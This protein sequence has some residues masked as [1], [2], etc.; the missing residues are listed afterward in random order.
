MKR[1]HIILILTIVAL[2]SIAGSAGAETGQRNF[3]AHLAG[4]GEVPAVDT[5][6]QGQAIFQLNEDGT[7]LH[8]KLIAANIDNLFM[9]HIHMGPAD[10]T[11]PI[12]VWL[13]LHPQ[14]ANPMDG[15][16]EGRFDGVLAEG[17]ITADDLT[18]PLGGGSLGDLLEAMRAGNTY[19]NVHTLQNPSGEVRGQIH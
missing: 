4:D 7:E 14:P 16:I 2:L 13:Y 1:L 11:G 12:V 10:G 17:T 6:A 5:L 18:G 15:L 19:V 3:R 8:Y 9:A